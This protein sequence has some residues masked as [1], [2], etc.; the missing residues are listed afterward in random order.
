[1]DL[2]TPMA[3]LPAGDQGAESLVVTL[4]V[5]GDPNAN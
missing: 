4:V 3:E 5:M 1:M 2:M